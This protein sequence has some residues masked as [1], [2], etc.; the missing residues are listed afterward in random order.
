MS[1]EPPSTRRSPGENRTADEPRKQGW[2]SSFFKGLRG[3]GNGE[4]SLRDSVEALIE[5]REEQAEP[6]D[7]EEHTLIA[8]VLKLGTVTIEDAMVPRA[9]IDAVEDTIPLNEV[10]AAMTKTGHSRIPVYQGTL[11]DVIGMIHIRDV[12]GAVERANGNGKRPS[13]RSLVR[14]VLF[15]APSMR[16]LDLLLQMRK[17]RNHMALV[18][19]E[20]GGIDGLVTIEDLVEEIVGEIEEEHE[21]A[22]APRIEECPDGTIIVDAR[23]PIEDLEEKSGPLL[24]GTEELGDVD[25]LGGFVSVL[26]GRVPVRGELIVHEVSGLEF[27]IMDA[28]P[29]RVKR[30]RVRNM[31]AHPVAHGD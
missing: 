7:P 3:K 11:D 16:V 12:L 4:N 20:Y 23:L 6:I 28:D 27:E 1:E 14:Q 10:V 30:L 22:T 15:V 26:A 29:R 18:V 17:S 13:L 21:A 5:Q 24:A 25:T 8:N 31:P 2:L 9:D 19:D